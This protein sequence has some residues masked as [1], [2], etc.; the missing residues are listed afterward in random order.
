MA[1]SNLRP[2]KDL[3]SLCFCL[4][5]LKAAKMIAIRSSNTRPKALDPSHFYLK[6]LTTVNSSSVP[7]EL[8]SIAD[9]PEVSLKDLKAI[10]L[11]NRDS[12]SQSLW[13]GGNLTD[14][15]QLADIKPTLLPAFCNFSLS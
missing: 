5:K 8:V 6:K 2:W 4:E 13:E 3:A 1:S 14:T 9:N 15:F 11:R 7:L 12:V 10:P